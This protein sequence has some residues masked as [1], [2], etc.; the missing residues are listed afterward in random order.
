MATDAEWADAAKRC[1]DE[2]N[3]HCA[4]G[5]I[6]KWVAIRLIDGGS[7][8]VP[9]DKRREAIKHQLHERQCMYIQV[10]VDGMPP[11]H[12]LRMLALH[13]KVYDAGFRFSDPDGP[14]VIAPSTMEGMRDALTNIRRLRVG[15]RDH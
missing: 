9:Y 2:I 3:L 8:H 15:Y 7:D 12:A 10:P 1:S 11:E 13:R 5:N 14:E 6:G 4:M